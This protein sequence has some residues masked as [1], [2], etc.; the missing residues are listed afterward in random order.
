MTKRTKTKKMATFATTKQQGNKK[1]AHRLLF[2]YVK[3]QHDNWYRN[4]YY[5][6]KENI[7]AP[8]TPLIVAGSHQN[9]INDPLAVEFTFA[10]RPVRIFA[11]SNLF[12]S[13]KSAE[14]FHSIGLLPAYRLK[15]DG[16]ESLSKNYDVFTEA[17][18]HLI[19]GGTVAIFPEAT[20][21]DRH[22]L[23]DFSLAY[24]R[25]AFSAA[26]KTG[27]SKDIQILPISIH[28][29]DYF[30][31]RAEIMIA[32]GN[33]ISI[34]DYYELF[35][36]KP[37]TAQREINA[38]VRKSI[39]TMM[40]NIT[41]TPNYDAI[42]FAC[43][44]LDNTDPEKTLPFTLVDNQR[45]VRGLNAK[46]EANIEDYEQLCNDIR[47]YKNELESKK[48][49]DWA[50]SKK[51]SIT[52]ICLDLLILICLLPI[53]I[54]SLFPALISELAPLPL[55]RK[56]RSLGGPFVMFEGGCR[57]VLN[58]LF[59]LPICAIIGFVAAVALSPGWIGIVLGVSYAYLI[60]FQNYRIF[61]EYNRI[62]L[63]ITA[64]IRANTAIRNDKEGILTKKR[65]SLIQ[66]IR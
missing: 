39:E 15:N 3:K 2:N 62:A 48:L 58:A 9:A 61:T 49:K 14:F 42:E 12:K 29:S 4:I 44:N 40:L 19:N 18:E 66:R 24:L 30:C 53:Y 63:D 34:S 60:L 55:V 47:N 25:M 36:T 31:H 8:G 50:I 5:V 57:F 17:E 35:K 46:R 21:Q 16:E 13:K 6:G 32:I 11:N 27:F 10:D 22:W 38:L 59:I 1:M 26:E 7:P 54:W 41:D 43:S 64:R 37:R 56:F 23:G 52:G 65:A 33:P 28:Y 51:Q 45:I 20:N